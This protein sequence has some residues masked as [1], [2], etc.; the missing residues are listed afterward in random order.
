MLEYFYLGVLISI[1]LWP[2]FANISDLLIAITDYFKSI[3][4]L[5][6]SKINLQINQLADE[7]EPQNSFAMGFQAPEREE[8]I[9]DYCD[10]IKK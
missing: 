7:M 9:D 1:G 3:I 4:N 8:E 10:K 6:I 2:V 5:K